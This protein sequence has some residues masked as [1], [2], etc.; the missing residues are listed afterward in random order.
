MNLHKDIEELVKANVIS[1]ETA[2]N[3]KQFYTDKEKTNHSR[4]FV[5]FGVLGA[6]LV[7]LG[8]ILIIGH[9]WDN[10]SRI[11]KTIIAFFPLVV[12]HLIGVYVLL[13][14]Q[15][16]TSWREGISAFLFFAVGATIAMISQ[17]YNLHGALTDFLLAW[18]LLSLPMVYIFHSTIGSLLYIA[19]ISYYAT[20]IG[21]FNHTRYETNYFLLLFIAI[22]PMYYGLY[23]N[24]PNSN[25]MSF[26][27][28]FISLSLAICLGTLLHINE[29]M[30]PIVYLYF[31]T[32]LYI[33]GNLNFFKNKKLRNNAYLL[34]GSLGNVITLL[35]LSFDG[36]WKELRYEKTQLSE[37]FISKEFGLITLLIIASSV[38][39][40]F[41]WKGKS[42]N[43]I[44]PIGAIFLSFIFIFLIGTHSNLAVIL[45]NILLL[46]IGILT[47]RN[48]VKY[49]H[50]GILNYGL[51]VIT[52]LVI[53]RFFDRNLSFVTRGLLFISVG[54]GFFMVN[55][56]ML[57]KRKKS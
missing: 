19:G 27:N 11:T 40:F 49:N 9:N 52:A 21:Y 35:I 42:L 23:K 4:L 24:K 56:Q 5:V 8:I 53:S 20:Q 39:L 25:G 1:N 12:A 18:M 55:Y 29:I 34:I 17:I 14:K 50:L 45:V 51:L 13:K 41:Q 3:I 43:K 31:F 30:I 10:L 16:S 28:W 44:N 36:Y 57:K 32:L 54:V 6:I 38:L 15:D 48:G 37:W 46:S 33:I 22:L 2:E 26:H 7:S 47:V